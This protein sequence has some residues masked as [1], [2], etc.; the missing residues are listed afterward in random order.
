MTSVLRLREACAHTSLDSVGRVS[1]ARSITVID[2]Q[3]WQ[4]Y[5]QYLPDGMQA[6][7]QGGYFW[8]FPAD[9]QAMS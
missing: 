1:A 7:F 8:K 6:F 2:M 5:R 3:N 9:F 4:Q